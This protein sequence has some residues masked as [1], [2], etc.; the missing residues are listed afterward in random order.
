MSGDAGADLELESMIADMVLGSTGL[1]FCLGLCCKPGTWVYWG[2][3]GAGVN[4][5]WPGVWVHR[6]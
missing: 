6:S 4:W 1:G 5:A 2:G 3:P